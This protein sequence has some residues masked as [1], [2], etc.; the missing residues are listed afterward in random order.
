MLS[1]NII[2]VYRIYMLTNMGHTSCYNVLTHLEQRFP[3]LK[4]QYYVGLKSYIRAFDEETNVMWFLLD[5][6]NPYTLRLM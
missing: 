5:S 6:R 3:N 1:D 2:E 4:F